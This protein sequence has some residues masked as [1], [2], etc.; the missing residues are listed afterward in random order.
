MIMK[1]DLTTIDNYVTNI[2]PEWRNETPNLMDSFDELTLE[3]G[4]ILP[5][6]RGDIFYLASGTIGKYH[7]KE[8]IRYI[9]TGELIIIPL[10]P[11]ILLFKALTDS[12]VMLLQRDALYRIVRQFPESIVLYDQLLSSQQ[13]SIEFRNYIL[14][15]PKGDRLEAFRVRYPAVSSLISRKE[16]AEF[17]NISIE[18]LRKAF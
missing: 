12:T 13:E 3:Y 8:P 15:L 16:L 9:D 1:K 17:L 18:S 4:E 5:Y 11:N 2:W 10:K 7:K 6:Q 14:K